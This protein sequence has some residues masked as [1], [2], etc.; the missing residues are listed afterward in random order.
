MHFDWKAIAR[1]GAAVVAGQTGHPEIVSAESAAEAA[2]A[3]TQAHKSVGD[4]VDG[5]AALAIQVIETA[6][7]FHG[8]ELVD[9]VQ[10]QRL[11]QGVHDS[12]SALAAGLAAKKITAGG[13]PVGVLVPPSTTGQ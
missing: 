1:I 12:L 8:S 13:V 7:G 5:Y 11:I 10:V 9:D 4:Q 3:S 6:E 2:V